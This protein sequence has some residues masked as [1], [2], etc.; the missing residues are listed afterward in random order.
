MVAMVGL[1]AAREMKE[2]ILAVWVT[3]QV[4]H[5]AKEIMEEMPL[6]VL[7]IMALAGAAALAAL[8]VQVQRQL[9]E[10]VD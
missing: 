7:L 8:E 9:V 4:L 5:Q 1:A 3:H 10:M 2:I 6:A